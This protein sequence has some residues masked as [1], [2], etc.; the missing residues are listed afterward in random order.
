VC[1]FSQ[2]DTTE[3]DCIPASLTKKVIQDLADCDVDRAE[4]DNLRADSIN[5]MKAI[6]FYEQ[7]LKSCESAS[8]SL[9]VTIRNQERIETM[10]GNEIRY[11]QSEYKTVR[12]QRN[13][14]YGA[15]GA[16]VITGGLR[17]I[18]IL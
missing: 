2:S 11:W 6:A 3:I 7:S 5:L 8:D 15:I 9:F 14:A 18:G 16:M 1:A 4:R 17:L 10:Q 13:V 12:R